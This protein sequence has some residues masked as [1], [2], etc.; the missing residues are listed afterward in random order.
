MK[1]KKFIK[2]IRRLVFL[3]LFVLIALLGMSP[4]YIYEQFNT[5]VP[6]AKLEF[7]QISNQEFIAKLSQG[8]FCEQEQFAIFGDQWRLDAS[9]MKWKGPAVALGLESRYRLD[10]LEGRYRIAAEQNTSKTMAHNLAPEVWLDIFEDKEVEG[11]PRYLIDTT[12]GTSVYLD[13]DT[14]KIY[15]VYKT[16]DGLIAKAEARPV[17]E[18]QNGLLVIEVNRGC[19]MAP[20][21]I[22]ELVDNLATEVN[23][24]AL[25]LF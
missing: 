23:Q 11:E 4:F 3:S 7:Q 22:T 5:E 9:F 16:E 8:D 6:V 24:L 15:T 10:R 18:Y 21:F 20:P 19:G 1:I 25:K 14:Q 13:I 17:P 2:L 12:F